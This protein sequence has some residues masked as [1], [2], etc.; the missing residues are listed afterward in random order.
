MTF[1]C[2]DKCKKERS[3][4]GY[5]KNHPKCSICMVTYETTSKRCY[6]CNN[7]LSRRKSRQHNLKTKEIIITRY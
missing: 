3:T 2:K 7:I 5:N 1:K 6:C 4:S